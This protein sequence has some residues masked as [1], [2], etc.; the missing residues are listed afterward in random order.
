MPLHDTYAGK[1]LVMRVR[2][3]FKDGRTAETDSKF[4]Y[5][6]SSPEITLNTDWKNLL[7]N[8]THT[9]T[10][11][12]LEGDLQL[13]WSTNVGANI[14]MTSPLV[15]N[16]KVYTASIDEDLKGHAAIYALNGMGYA[17]E[18]PQPPC[19][20]HYYI[21]LLKRVSLS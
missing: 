4:V 20:A 12:P 6:K 10:A 15:Y 13:A 8:A 21:S 9:A 18:G 5:E 14:F 19:T 16:N 7:G 11:A 1:E 2:T 17:I 3:R